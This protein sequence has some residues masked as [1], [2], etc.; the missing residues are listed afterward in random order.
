MVATHGANI[1]IFAFRFKELLARICQDIRDNVAAND[2]SPDNSALGDALSNDSDPDDGWLDRY[3]S[4]VFV[5][6]TIQI[7]TDSTR[8]YRT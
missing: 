7:N 8:Q 3:N 4:N 1:Y 6:T 5:C 2:C